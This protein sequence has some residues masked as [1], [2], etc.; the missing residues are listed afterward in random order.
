[1]MPSGSQGNSCNTVLAAR[2]SFLQRPR[3][4][5][6]T[7]CSHLRT[8]LSWS[9][10][11]RSLLR[12]DTQSGTALSEAIYPWIAN[13]ER[14]LICDMAFEVKS[15]YLEDASEEFVMT[16]LGLATTEAAE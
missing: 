10:S 14:I 13:D 9:T 3:T 6:A 16:A 15:R 8:A 11:L 7:H 2:G 1:M 5:T 4:T 12:G